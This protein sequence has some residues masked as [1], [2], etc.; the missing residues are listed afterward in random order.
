MDLGEGFITTAVRE[1]LEETGIDLSNNTV[2]YD[3]LPAAAG[4]GSDAGAAAAAGSGGETDAAGAGSARPLHIFE[5]C[6]LNLN[7][8]SSS[9]HLIVRVVVADVP[10]DVDAV[11]MEPAKCA[12]RDPECCPEVD[13]DSVNAAHAPLSRERWVWL[14]GWAVFSAS[15]FRFRSP[16]AS[17]LLSLLSSPSLSAPPPRRQGW[18]WVPWEWVQAIALRKTNA[19]APAS[20]ST[21]A[22]SSAAP[23]AA[24]MGAAA[25]S[26]DL[27]APFDEGLVFAPLRVLARSGWTPFAARPDLPR[28]DPGQVELEIHQ[29]E[30]RRRAP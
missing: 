25:P 9:L 11:N 6:T 15:C 5:A 14:R 13:I 26:T 28:L 19:P 23:S 3:V 16:C 7:D 1:T 2:L 18:H 8:P 12:V 24:A 27:P 10:D 20:S 30:L 21:A 4:P 22:A 17:L 29:D